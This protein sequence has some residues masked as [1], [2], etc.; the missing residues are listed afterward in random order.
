MSFNDTAANINTTLANFEQL[1]KGLQETMRGE[2]KKVFAAFFAEF[3]Q[4]KTI[5][6]TQYTPYFND[7]DECTFRLNEMWFTTTEYTELNE[8]ECAYGEGDDGQINDWGKRIDDIALKT[9]ID[10][11]SSAMN[12]SMMENVLKTTY[13]DHAWV[14]VHKDGVDVEDF[15]HD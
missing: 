8:R 6:W 7:G 11:L 2:M 9:A 3:P 4:V 13:G 10:T 1:A 5:H 14:R 12:S 15:E